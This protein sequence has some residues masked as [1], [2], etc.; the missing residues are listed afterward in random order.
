MVSAIQGRIGTATIRPINLTQSAFDRDSVIMG[1][2]AE[3]I[4]LEGVLPG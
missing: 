4:K 3:S 1:A 2:A